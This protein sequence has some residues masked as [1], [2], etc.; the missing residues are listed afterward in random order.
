MKR[1]TFFVTA[2]LAASAAS[3]AVLEFSYNVDGVE[4]GYYGTKKKENYDIAIKIDNPALAGQKITGLKV[5]IPGDASLYTAPSAFL[6]TELVVE[7]IDGVRVNVPDICSVNATIADGYLTATFAEPYTLTSDPVYVGYAVEVDELTT[8]SKT[9][10][11][12]VPGHNTNGFWMHSSRTQLKWADYSD[13]VDEGMQSAMVVILEGDF[14]AESAGIAMPERTVC[15]T[16]QE[17]DY[18]FTVINGGTSPISEIG[19]SWELADQKGEGTFKFD[20]PIN[21]SLGAKGT[22][23]MVLPEINEKG[24]YTLKLKIETI[25]GTPNPNE[26]ASQEAKVIFAPAVPVNRPLVEE[27]TGLWCG[28]CVRGY[29]ALEYLFEEHHTDFVAAAWHAGDPMSISTAFPNNPGGYPFAYINRSIPLDPGQ[30]LTQWAIESEKPTD[31]SIVCDLK[32]TDDTKTSVT[33]TATVN[34]IADYDDSYSVGFMLVADGLCQ[35][36]N[37]LWGQ[38]NYY[39]GNSSA[40]NE[41]PGK[42]ADEFFKG[43]PTVMGLV[44]NDVV[45]STDNVLGIPKSL[46]QDIKAFEDYS[47]SAT[48]D[49]SEFRTNYITPTT[50][51]PDANLIPFDKDK[52]RVIAFIVGP[53]K[54]IVNS[55]TSKYANGEDPS[56]VNGIYN[57]ETDA[58]VVSTVWYDLQGRPVGNNAKGILLRV[59]TLSDGN[60]HVRKVAVK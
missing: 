3:A 14:P 1:L 56:D 39:S 11:A 6:T 16:G 31:F 7:R 51:N 40:Y 21:G 29:A 50:S 45:L 34:S 58:E 60:V 48:Y 24:N 13:K 22:A 57:V 5:E 36:S 15:L 33:A 28:W 55:C 4:P 27:Y 41:L 20:T 35:P 47:C 17:N 10:I 43:N 18:F 53:D 12:V 38:K 52:I 59:D 19:Y 37:A 8:I 25:N 30:L 54:S 26:S 23:A 32:Y 42:Y 9:P 2:A 44:F 49:I 46:P